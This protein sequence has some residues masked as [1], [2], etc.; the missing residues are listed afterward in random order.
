[1]TTTSAVSGSGR[2]DRTGSAAIVALQSERRSK[3]VF[4]SVVATGE[5]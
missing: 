1:M 5:G 4:M 2:P 3:S